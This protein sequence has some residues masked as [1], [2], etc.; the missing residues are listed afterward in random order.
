LFLF[1]GKSTE[2]WIGIVLWGVAIG[3]QNALFRSVLAGLLPPGV[4]STG[5]GIFGLVFGLAWF[6]GG[7]LVGRLYDQAIALSALASIG[8]QVLALPFLRKLQ[9]RA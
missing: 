3:G 8:L 2:V 6:V 1:L 5:Y 9:L 4:R 7:A